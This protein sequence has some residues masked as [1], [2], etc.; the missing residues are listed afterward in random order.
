VTGSFLVGGRHA[1]GIHRPGVLNPA[2]KK[3]A[4]R[5]S[6]QQAARFS[7][8]PWQASILTG[9]AVAA[10]R[11]WL[12]RNSYASGRQNADGDQD[13]KAGDKQDP[14][15]LLDDV[16]GLGAPPI[17]VSFLPDATR[18]ILAS[19]VKETV[20]KQAWNSVDLHQ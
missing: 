15:I 11:P 4:A 17:L 7:N 1:G 6:C 16:H 3:G 20:T 2:D 12:G 14:A 19:P 8:E 10:L 18:N 13:G 9:S 5:W